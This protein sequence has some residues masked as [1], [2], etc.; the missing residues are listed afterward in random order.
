MISEKQT[1]MLVRSGVIL[2][3]AGT[4]LMASFAANSLKEMSFMGESTKVTPTISV[5]GEGNSYAKPDMATLSFSVKA[6]SKEQKKATDDINSTMK[7]LVDAL[8]SAGLSES[9]IQTTDYNLYPQYDYI[10]Q[11]CPDIKTIMIQQPCT[12]GK[13]VLRGYEASQRIQLSIKGKDNFEKVATFVDIV[14]KNGATDVGQLEFKVEKPEK[15][16]AEAREDAIKQAKDKAEKLADQLD[17]ELVR[18]T[19]FYE[20]NYSPVYNGRAMMAKESMDMAGGMA[21]TLP[22]G[23]NQFKSN[24]TITYEIAD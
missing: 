16:Q 23:Q 18:I 15:A 17:V 13:Q 14:S 10:Q 2:A 19:G 12:P 8:K 24:I 20:N 21:P 7:K 9:D 22:V 5:S 4:V 11:V 1:T 6:E 3:V